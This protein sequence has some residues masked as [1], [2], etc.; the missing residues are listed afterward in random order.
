MNYYHDGNLKMGY[1]SDSAAELKKG[2]GVAIVSLGAERVISYRSKLDPE[3]KVKYG[4]ENGALLYMG[5]DVQE[6]W[7]H[8][9]PKAKNVET[10]ISLTFRQII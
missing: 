3:Y 2:T 6:Q 4:L 10:R 5:N 7:M 8:A 1:Y 9:I